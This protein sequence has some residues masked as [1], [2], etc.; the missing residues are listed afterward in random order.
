MFVPESVCVSLSVTM[1]F[2]NLIWVVFVFVCVCVFVCLF[3]SAPLSV[4]VAQ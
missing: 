1:E 2:F 4:C 3:V